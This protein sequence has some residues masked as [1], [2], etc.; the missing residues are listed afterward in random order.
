MILGFIMGYLGTVLAPT[1]LPWLWALLIGVG[2]TSFPLGLYL[3]TQ[4]AA[5]PPGVLALS[6]FMQGVGYLVAGVAVIL[7]GAG[8]ETRRTGPLH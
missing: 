8:V 1:A 7:V 4:G 2:T 6:G 5:T 3:V